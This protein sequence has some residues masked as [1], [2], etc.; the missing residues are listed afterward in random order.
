MAEAI[1]PTMDTEQP[2]ADSKARSQLNQPAPLSGM[3]LAIV[4]FALSMAVF[5]MVLDSTIA[6]VAL[7]GIWVRRP[8][9]VHG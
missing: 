9:K 2:A 8:R 3:P 1:S 4:T 5:M 6:N 7:Q